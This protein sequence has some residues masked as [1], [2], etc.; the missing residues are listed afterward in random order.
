MDLNKFKRILLD[1]TSE[2]TDFIKSSD[3]RVKTIYGPKLSARLQNLSGIY[4]FPNYTQSAFENQE[5]GEGDFRIQFKF[6]GF[7]QRGQYQIPQLEI[8]N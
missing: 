3:L 7:Q 4:I 1:A 6:L 8:I 2:R 5:F